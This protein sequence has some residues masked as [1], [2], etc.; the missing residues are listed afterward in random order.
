MGYWYVS[1]GTLKFA[2][3]EGWNVAEAVV[4]KVADTIFPRDGKLLIFFE[5]WKF[6]E[7]PISTFYLPE[8]K[9]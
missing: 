5:G 8:L 3:I 4:W 2:D 6:A 9:L 1:V 7:K